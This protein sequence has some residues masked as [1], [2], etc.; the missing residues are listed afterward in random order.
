MIASKAVPQTIIAL[1]ERIDIAAFVDV[2]IKYLRTQGMEIP[3]VRIVNL[4]ELENLPQY[5]DDLEQFVEPANIGKVLILADASKKRLERQYFITAAL[6]RSLLQNLEYDFYLFPRKSEKGNWTPGFMED[7][8]LPT[9]S[10]E[11]SE[12]CEFYNLHSITHEFLFS[13]Q[14]CRGKGNRFVNIS[15]NFLYSY[16]SGT[17]KFVGMRLGEAAEKGIFDFEHENFRD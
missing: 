12:E 4:Q 7:L 16:L 9:L 6:Q 15:R 11:S 13:V 14:N 2:Y 1:C 5:L 10:Q 8:L 3:K 17:E